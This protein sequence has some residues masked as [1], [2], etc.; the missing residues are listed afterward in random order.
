MLVR[1]LPT[2]IHLFQQEIVVQLEV[3]GRSAGR[4]RQFTQSFSDDRLRRTI[5]SHFEND[6]RFLFVAIGSR[7]LSAGSAHILNTVND[8]EEHAT[9]DSPTT[10]TTVRIVLLTGTGKSRGTFV[11][12]GSGRWSWFLIDFD[13]LLFDW[14]WL[15]FLFWLILIDWFLIDY[16]IFDWF[17]LIFLFWFCL[18]F[19]YWFCLIFWSC[20]F[21][22][23]DYLFFIFCF[24]CQQGWIIVTALISTKWAYKQTTWTSTERREFENRYFVLI[25]EL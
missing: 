21:I 18:M 15:F 22:M 13:W 7:G 9:L 12:I 5:L 25:G 1:R 3:D 17:W 20:F 24:S 2:T 11:L 19:F 16:L 8:E 10:T 23:A 6:V 4:R 14:F